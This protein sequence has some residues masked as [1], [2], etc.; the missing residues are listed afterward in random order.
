MTEY[1]TRLLSALDLLAPPADETPAWDDVAAR[2][3]AQPRF[4][5]KVAAV[6]LAVLATSAFVAG[7]FAQEQLHN[8]LDRLSSW[9]GQQPGSPDPEQQ[10]AFDIEN[11]GA[12][13]HFP[14]G[15]RVGRL[16]HADVGSRS[17]DLLGFRAGTD[18]CLR[19]VPSPIPRQRSAP[20]CVPQSELTRLGKPIAAVGGHIR[21]R[22]PDGS[23][24]TVVYGLAS[25]AIRSVDVLADGR[26][27]GAADVDNNA[28]LYAAP[29][30]PGSPVEGPALVVRAEDANGVAAEVPIASGPSFSRAQPSALPALPGPDR[31]ERTLTN[32]S[33]GWLESGE[34]RGEPFT[35]PDDYPQRVVHSRLIRPDASSAMRFGLAY[36]E[37]TTANTRGGWYCL[38]WLWPLIKDSLVSYCGR[39]EAVNAGISYTGALSSSGVQFPL[40]VGMASDQV[41]RIELFRADGSSQPVPLVDNVFTF[42]T[43]RLDPV[44]LVA[45]DDQNRVVTIEI[46]GTPDSSFRGEVQG[47]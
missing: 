45:Y 39:A 34:A 12:Y 30:R 31:V 26:L 41:A 21:A 27:L 23:G 17:F 47:P 9:A 28:F 1:E 11:A 37:G 36:A 42:Q 14:T 10:A 22:L 7:A 6:A 24:L 29:D 16:L 13:A 18:L 8:G 44:K 35:W 3:G 38:A 40:R 25:D 33:I 19:V 4:R 2:V 5:W 32:G 46:Q 20:E 15:T 43:W